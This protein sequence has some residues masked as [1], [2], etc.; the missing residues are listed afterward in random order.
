M[1][2]GVETSCFTRNNKGCERCNSGYYNI[3]SECEMCSNHCDNCYNTTYCLTC[4]PQYYLSS[5]FTCEPLGDLFTKCELTLPTGGGCAICKDHHYKQKTDC[6]ACDESCGTCV[7]GVSCLSCQ[8]EYFKLTGS[9][10][11]LCVSYDNLTNYET[12][13]PIGCLKCENGYYL[14]NNICKTCSENCISCNNYQNCKNCVGKDYV[15]VDSQCVNY[16]NVEFCLSANNSKCTKCDGF[17]KP[18][19]VGDYCVKE[20][21]YGLVVGVPLSV[22]VVI[23]VFI[24]A[25]ILIVISMIQKRKQKKKDQNICNFKMSRSNIEM[26]ELS[27]NLVS[28]KTTLNLIWITMTHLRST[29]RQEI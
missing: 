25:I 14:D 5:T 9:E 29:S 6:I 4:D 12:K 2:K 3:N 24:V 20:T 19:D 16:K 21:N 27:A 1:M 17:H 11:K 22:T 8:N 15:L 23:I 10:S 13:T 18:S 7:D 26:V 28:N